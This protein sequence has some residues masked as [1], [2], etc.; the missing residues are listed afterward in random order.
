LKSLNTVI[1]GKISD[2]EEIKSALPE[3]FLSKLENNKQ[4]FN[5]DTFEG[6][7]EDFQITEDMP[8][9]VKVKIY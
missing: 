3:D 7:N 6:E 1:G 5:D 4:Q 9:L 8:F 2:D